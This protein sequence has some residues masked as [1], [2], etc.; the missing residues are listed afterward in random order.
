MFTLTAWSSLS[1]HRA[2]GGT[3]SQAS[4]LQRAM[5]VRLSVRTV[6]GLSYCTATLSG[7]QASLKSRAS[8]PTKQI[9]F[10]FSIRN[11]CLVKMFLICWKCDTEQQKDGLGS[12]RISR[13]INSRLWRSRPVKTFYLTLFPVYLFILSHVLVAWGQSPRSEAVRMASVPGSSSGSY[14]THTPSGLIL[15]TCTDHSISKKS[16]S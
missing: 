16:T 4:Q 14:V 13:F 11:G 10:V 5:G 7:R 6:K 12:H 2:A 9:A 8:L 1:W 3:C 15:L